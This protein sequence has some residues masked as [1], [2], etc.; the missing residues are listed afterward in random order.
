MFDEEVPDIKRTIGTPTKTQETVARH[1]VDEAVVHEKGGEQA[2][3]F[4]KKGCVVDLF[5]DIR[6]HMGL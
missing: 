5:L 2:R 3:D 4:R 6:R 1:W